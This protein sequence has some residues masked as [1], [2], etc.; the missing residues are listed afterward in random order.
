[1]GPT[2]HTVQKQRTKNNPEYKQSKENLLWAMQIYEAAGQP[3]PWDL[4]KHMA[5]TYAG[6]Q[7]TEAAIEMY[8]KALDASDQ[9]TDSEKEQM[10]QAIQELQQP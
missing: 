8:Q 3:V 9:I 6:L 5:M 1:M 2:G 4:Y 10:Q 7:D